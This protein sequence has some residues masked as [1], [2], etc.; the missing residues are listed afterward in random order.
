MRLLHTAD[1]HLGARLIEQDRGP[2]HQRFLD[3]LL[4]QIRELEP[5]LLVIAGD[6]FDSANPPQQAMAQYYAFLAEVA[7]T[8]TEVLVLGGNHD[9][10]LTLNAPR[11]LLRSLR[12]RVIGAAPADPQD[13]IIEL[14]EAVLC[15]VPYLRERD[16][17]LA[18]P[19]QTS[20][21][22]A[23]QLRE[24][25][26]R[27]YRQLFEL[28]S[29]RAKGRPILATGHL[30][31]VGG[32]S[33]ASERSIQIGNLAAVPADCFAGF[34]YVALGHLH[35]PQQVGGCAHLR[36]A[37]SP[38]ALGFDE[39][40]VAKEVLLVTIG[41]TAA[42]ALEIRPIAVPC[43][44]RLVRIH[45]GLDGL[46]AKLGAI[47][48]SPDELDPWLEITIENAGNEPALDARV[49]DALGLV[50]ATILKVLAP[51]GGHAAVGAD[52]VFEGRSLAEIR[53]EEVFAE[54]LRRA[55]IEPASDEA[56]ALEET[57]AELL[58]RM[59]EDAAIGLAEGV[60]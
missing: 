3:W 53:P 36:Y 12:I 39:A 23:V 44:R 2:E 17:R 46:A 59:Q 14:P 35:R 28:A 33:S 48:P 8:S 47:A 54:R 38:V 60:R 50:R 55:G 13:A 51:R 5:Q 42:E 9:S 37:G 20:A 19:G 27:H 31:A 6:V 1:W 4:G 52:S 49:R 24:G 16:V 25:I 58:M 41:G 10:P 21:E 57:F 40:G 15:A 32:E 56:R 45:S 30:T 22:V 11:D 34:A 29:A 7:R 43:A 26:T 18:A